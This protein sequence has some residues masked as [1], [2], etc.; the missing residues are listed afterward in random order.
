MFCMLMY[1]VLSLPSTVKG[2]INPK[3]NL[4]YALHKLYFFLRWHFFVIFSWIWRTGYGRWSCNWLRHL[5]LRQHQFYV[6][7]IRYWSPHHEDQRESFSTSLIDPFCLPFTIVLCYKFVVICFFWFYVHYCTVIQCTMRAAQAGKIMGPSSSTP[8]GRVTRCSG[9][10]DKENQ[11]Q[12]ANGWPGYK[13]VFFF[14]WFGRK[15]RPLRITLGA[16]GFF[17][18]L[19]KHSSCLHIVKQ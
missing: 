6:R 5:W 16:T 10:D 12:L 14:G 17:W 11:Q 9:N 18:W 13:D 7:F 15:K 1:V 19:S 3:D 8:C 4:L 2:S